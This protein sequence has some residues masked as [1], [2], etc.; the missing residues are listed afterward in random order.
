MLLKGS[1]ENV[2]KLCSRLYPGLGKK[3]G[4]CQLSYKI[5]PKVILKPLK[6]LKLRKI[7]FSYQL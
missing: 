2:K 7:A 6:Y 4:C 1:R 3:P 5:K